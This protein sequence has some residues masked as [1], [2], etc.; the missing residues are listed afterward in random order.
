MYGVL[1]VTAQG[2]S[3]LGTAGIEAGLTVP[4]YAFKVGGDVV[5]PIAGAFGIESYATTKTDK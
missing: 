2:L 1:G 4:G 5:A 3:V